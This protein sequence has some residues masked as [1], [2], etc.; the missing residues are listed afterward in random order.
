WGIPPLLS[1]WLAL[2]VEC[3]E[4]KFV[5]QKYCLVKQ[6]PALRNKTANRICRSSRA[7]PKLSLCIGHALCYYYFAPYRGCLFH[8]FDRK[9]IRKTRAS[10]LCLSGL[11]VCSFSAIGKYLS[12][13]LFGQEGSVLSL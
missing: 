11:C 1:L 10:N 5:L 9:S 4:Y 12:G 13:D 7:K 6:A 2:T 8:T 3:K